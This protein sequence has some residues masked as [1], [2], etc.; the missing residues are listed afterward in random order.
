MNESWSGKTE[1]LRPC[2]NEPWQGKTRALRSCHN[3]S[4]QGTLRA[5]RPCDN[6]SWSEKTERLRPCGYE[7]SQEIS[8][9]SR[10]CG[11]EPYQGIIRAVRRSL[12]ES[13]WWQA[14]KDCTTRRSGVNNAL[15]ARPSPAWPICLVARYQRAVQYQGSCFRSRA[16]LAVLSA[17]LALFSP[18]RDHNFGKK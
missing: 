16:G 14:T 8:R 12:N 4:E 15:E 1:T 13:W 9:V 10:P 6:E 2:G 11:Y 5:S 18:H 17:A 7:S 3:E